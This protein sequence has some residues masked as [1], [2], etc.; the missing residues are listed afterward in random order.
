M[1]SWGS[2]WRPAVENRHRK[3]DRRPDEHHSNGVRRQRV[4]SDPLDRG[5][6]Q[7]GQETVHQPD[8]RIQ[9]ENPDKAD[10]NGCDDRR[11]EDERPES[12]DGGEPPI[13]QE[14]QAEGQGDDHDHCDDE[15]DDRIA[16]GGPEERVSARRE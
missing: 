8:A 7:K 6:P 10:E 16:Q 2:C 4:S 12:T 9:D 15:N 11:S 14:G 3:A 13:E 1:T 5:Q